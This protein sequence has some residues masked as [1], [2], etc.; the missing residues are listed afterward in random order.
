MVRYSI[1]LVGGTVPHYD[2]STPGRFEKRD[3]DWLSQIVAARHC[4]VSKYGALS[5]QWWM[6]GHVS[7]GLIGLATRPDLV[8]TSN[9]T[10]TPSRRGFIL[11]WFP[12]GMALFRQY[13]GVC[14]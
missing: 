14:S 13:S 2:W 10:I 3:S 1:G 12:H 5:V 11:N 4:V 8:T 6:A 9:I 7:V